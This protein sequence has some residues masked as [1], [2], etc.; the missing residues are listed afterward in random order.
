MPQFLVEHSADVNAQDG[1]KSTPL[2]LALMGGHI[3]FARK[4]VEHGANV[5]AQD[6][7]KSTRLHLASIRGIHL[8]ARWT[9]CGC[10]CTGRVR[11]DPVRSSI[12]KGIS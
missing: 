3:E 10:E 7:C 2:H 1:W 12:Q 11:E 5:N 6:S 4:L 9:W 8:E